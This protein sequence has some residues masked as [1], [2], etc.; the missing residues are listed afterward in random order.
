VRRDA[1]VEAHASH[2]LVPFVG[3]WRTKAT[4]TK[5]EAL[6]RIQRAQRDLGT[7]DF[8]TVARAYSEGPSA[9]AGG[10]LGIVA[11]GQMV[12]TFED[13]LFSLAPG[14]VSEPVESPYGYHLILRH[15]Q[16]E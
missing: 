14:A 6:E 15:A 11:P 7:K 4:R 13:A 8:G 1:V 10:D 3:A 9:S 2:I 5:A 16:G 12:P